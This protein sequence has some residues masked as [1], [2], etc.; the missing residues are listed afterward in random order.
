[1]EAIAVEPKA[2]KAQ[3]KEFFARAV[4]DDHRPRRVMRIKMSVPTFEKYFPRERDADWNIPQSATCPE[5]RDLIRTNT[6]CCF[7]RIWGVTVKVAHALPLGTIE[8]YAVG[9]VGA[10]PLLTSWTF[11]DVTPNA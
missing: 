3:M 5:L 8:L 9:G 1:L 6:P 10:G 11:E 2:V 4:G 7:A